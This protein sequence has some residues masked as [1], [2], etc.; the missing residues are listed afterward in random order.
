MTVEAACIEQ[1]RTYTYRLAVTQ[2]LGRI[3]FDEAHLTIIAFNYRQA[4]VNL[5]L[6]RNVRT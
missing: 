5:A 3:V 1:F 2:D 4:M 6:I